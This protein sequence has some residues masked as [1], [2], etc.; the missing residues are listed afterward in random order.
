MRMRI[1]YPGREAE[2]E[3]LRNSDHNP[4]DFVRPVISGEE[5]VHLQAQVNR[6]AWTMRWWT[7]CSPSSR[8]RAL[9][10][11]FRWA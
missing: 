7:T 11:L 1:G 9:M 4:G 2:R 10:R 5:L 8:R 6:I 3:I